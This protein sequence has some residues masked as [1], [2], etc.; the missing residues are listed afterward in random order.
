M[1]DTA[2]VAARIRKRLDDEEFYAGSPQPIP[3][4]VKALLRDALTALDAAQPSP[5]DPADVAAAAVVL[6]ERLSTVTVPYDGVED[7]EVHVC[8]R[9]GCGRRAWDDGIPLTYV[10]VVVLPGEE[11]YGEVVQALCDTHLQM[12]RHALMALGFV[13]H[14]HHGTQMLDRPDVCGGYSGC[15]TPTRYGAE[16]VQPAG[17]DADRAVDRDDL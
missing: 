13:S 16:L 7:E 12:M 3:G 8:S 6:P 1:A 10:R 5:Q 4:D 15:A 17:S 9:P 14:N 2:D 11:G